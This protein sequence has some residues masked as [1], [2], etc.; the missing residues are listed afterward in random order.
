MN[1]AFE[2][3]LATKGIIHLVT[4]PYIPQQNGMAK[5]KHRHILEI[6]IT[7]ISTASMP[8]NFW[9]HACA[10]AVIFINRMPCKSLSM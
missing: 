2:K 8:H 1:G 9:Y 3:F 4:Y 10:H 7:L 6:T 5:R